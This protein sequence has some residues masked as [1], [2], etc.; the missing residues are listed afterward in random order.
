MLK[1]AFVSTYKLAFVR[2]FAQIAKLR[3]QF[4]TINYVDIIDWVDKNCFP[5]IIA[6][7]L[8]MRTNL[9]NKIW[10]EI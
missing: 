4:Q 6:R 2:L 9:S 1:C 8:I 5:Q 7:P 3:A 10:Y